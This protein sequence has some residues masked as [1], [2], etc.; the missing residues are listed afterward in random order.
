MDFALSAKYGSFVTPMSTSMSVSSG[1]GEI[2]RELS[3]SW[4]KIVIIHNLCSKDAGLGALSAFCVASSRRTRRG[5][6][7]VSVS[8]DVRIRR[9]ASVGGLKEESRMY[10]VFGGG[11]G[12]LDG[13]RTGR[14][15]KIRKV[16]GEEAKDLRAVV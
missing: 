8:A 3:K 13:D 1:A 9:C 11:R 14:E 15:D 10:S 4:A 12:W 5:R 6:G 7:V 2:G 16:D